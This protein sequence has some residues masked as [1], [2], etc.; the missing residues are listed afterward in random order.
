MNRRG[1]GRQQESSLAPVALWLV[2]VD[3]WGTEKTGSAILTCPADMCTVP[4]P[5]CGPLRTVEER[6]F[7]LPKRHKNNNNYR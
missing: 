3:A 6:A 1:K 4:C 5:K 2:A 7:F